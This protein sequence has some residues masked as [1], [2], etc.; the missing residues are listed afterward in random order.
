MADFPVD[1]TTLAAI[2]GMAGITTTIIFQ[3]RS[4]RKEQ[5]AKQEADKNQI[6]EQINEKV[7]AKLEVITVT[8]NSLEKAFEEFKSLNRQD[9]INLKLQLEELEE[10]VKHAEREDGEV[11]KDL[12]K[13]IMDVYTHI[14]DLEIKLERK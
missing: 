3:I 13:R 10:D 8:T 12:E 7:K 11:R 4:F 5:A 2:L 14:A 1:I 9:L 6:I